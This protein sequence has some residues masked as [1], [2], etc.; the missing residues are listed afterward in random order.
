MWQHLRGLQIVGGYMI[1]NIRRNW[2]SR[3]NGEDLKPFRVAPRW[4]QEA[5]NVLATCGTAHS[6][7]SPPLVTHVARDC[8][9]LPGFMNIYCAVRAPHSGPLPLRCR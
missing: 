2:S 7:Q 6:L 3:A 4:V 9:I 5:H 8:M 1:R